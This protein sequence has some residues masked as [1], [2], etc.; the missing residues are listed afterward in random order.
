MPLIADE[1]VTYGYQAEDRHMVK[2]FLE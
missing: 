2:S 1:A